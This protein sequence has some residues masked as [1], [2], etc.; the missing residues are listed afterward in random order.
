[1]ITARSLLRCAWFASSLV[2]ASCHSG[3]PTPIDHSFKNE[4]RICL[5]P[6][7]V[8]PGN[9]FLPPSEPLLFQADH[10]ARVTVM[11]PACLSGSCSHDAQAACTVS[12]QG[13]VLEVASTASFRDEGSVCTTDC[14]ALV[15]RCA[16]PPL[17]AGTYQVRHGVETITLTVPSTAVPPCAGKAP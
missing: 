9:A 4:G 10:P 1:M 5:F 7:D 15:A 8:D 13:N 11:A 12:V 6:D 3:A 14:G 16:T 2:L 17:P